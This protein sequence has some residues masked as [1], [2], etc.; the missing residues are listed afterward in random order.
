LIEQLKS[1]K[2]ETLTD[3]ISCWSGDEFVADWPQLIEDELVG[4]RGSG[5]WT[6]AQTAPIT[7]IGTGKPKV[8]EWATR[9]MSV[10]YWLAT[11]FEWIL[12]ESF[13]GS[14]Y[15]AVGPISVAEL[16][17]A[18][19]CDANEHSVEHQLLAQAALALEVSGSQILQAAFMCQHLGLQQLE[20]PLARYLSRSWSRYLNHPSELTFDWSLY[21]SLTARSL[22]RSLGRSWAQELV[23]TRD[24]PETRQMLAQNLST[25]TDSAPLNFP[26]TKE[27]AILPLVAAT[28][29][30]AFQPDCEDRRL[31]T[32]KQVQPAL[33]AKDDWTRLLAINNLITLSAGTPELVRERNRLCDLAMKTPDKFT[34]PAELVE[35]TKD[36][37]WF[38]LPEIIAIIFLHGFDEDGKSDPFLKPEWFDPKS[39]ESKFFLSPPREFFALAAEV[40]DPKGETDLA[41]WRKS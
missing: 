14:S 33:N 11:S 25:A 27:W 37:E 1:A 7:L 38:N 18:L 29:W 41:K 22:V 8:I 12:Q 6:P 19:V 23:N 4:Q 30:L 34:F 40:L 20:E 3:R 15:A 24:W 5:N 31:E 16:N 13:D 17:I 2:P 21:K 10:H 39:K 36:K 26:K 9:R 35:A 28:E 32:I